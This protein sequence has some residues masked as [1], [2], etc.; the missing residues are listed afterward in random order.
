[1]A[2][3]QPQLREMKANRIFT[4]RRKKPARKTSINAR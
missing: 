2:A 3:L 4:P 1:V